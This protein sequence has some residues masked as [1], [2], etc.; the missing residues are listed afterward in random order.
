MNLSHTWENEG[1]CTMS[2]EV[3]ELGHYLLPF[4]LVK[5]LLLLGNH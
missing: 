1:V 3:A 4:S 2:G 5:F